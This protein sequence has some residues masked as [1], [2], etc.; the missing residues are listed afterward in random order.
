MTKAIEVK[1][2]VKNYENIQAVKGIS[3]DVEKNSFFAFL[4]PNGAGK[5]TTINIIST[6]LDYNSGD[7]FISGNKLGKNDNLIRNKIGIVFQN[8]ML[9]DFLTVKENLTIRASF[10]GID[11]IGLEKRIDEIDEFLEIKSIYSQRYGKLSGGQKRKADIARALIHWPEILILDEPTTGLDPKSR[12]DIWE[13]INK[14]RIAKELTI[15]LTTH[16]MEEV[17]D[18]NKIVVIDKGEIL[19]TGSSEELRLKYSHD[20][21]KIIPMNGLKQRLIDDHVEFYETNQMINIV[22]D[23]CFKGL[24]FID[25]YKKYIKE[26][27]ILRGDMDDVFLNITGRKLVD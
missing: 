13:L 18:A 8:S 27:E 1:N 20:R 4:G 23:N 26:F 11:K 10:Y 3:F 15:F 14:L 19:A 21:I 2:L 22:L 7:V 12:K 16:Y 17:I 5:S 25:K 24:D 6:L 9:D